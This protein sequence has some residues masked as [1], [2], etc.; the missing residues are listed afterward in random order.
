MI[1]RFQVSTSTMKEEE[2]ASKGQPSSTSSQIETTETIKMVQLLDLVKP[3]LPSDNCE[4]N[5]LDQIDYPP[6]KRDQIPQPQTDPSFFI[7]SQEIIPRLEDPYFMDVFGRSDSS[8]FDHGAQLSLTPDT[9]F[10]DFP[11]DMFDHIDPLPNL[12]DW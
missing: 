10:D 7:E 1:F 11:T 12:S 6:I 4:A 8:E 9:F 5:I 2:S 3:K